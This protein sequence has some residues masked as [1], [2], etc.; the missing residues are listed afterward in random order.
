VHLV[1]LCSGAYHG[2]KAAAAGGALRSIVVVNPLTFFWK[3][4]M[5]LDYADFQ[6]TSESIR[7]ARSATTLTSWLKLL[8]G[9]VDMRAAATV[10]WKRLNAIARNTLRDVARRLRMRL[11]DD[12]ASELLHIARQRTDMYFVF[13]ASDPGHAM[14]CEQGGSIIRRLRRRD[15]LRISIVQGADHTFTAHWN[16]DQLVALLM[17]HLDR[18]VATA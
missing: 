16:R 18:H 5:P 9:Q 6:V 1:G 13:S 8:R 15:Q 10:F 11:D 7:Y 14:L 3:P 17:A 12:L 4:G 2:L